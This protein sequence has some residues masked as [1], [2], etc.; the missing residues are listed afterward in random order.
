MDGDMSYYRTYTPS[1]FK[2]APVVSP[3]MIAI[4]VFISGLAVGLVLGAA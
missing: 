3:L 1:G 4:A 2:P